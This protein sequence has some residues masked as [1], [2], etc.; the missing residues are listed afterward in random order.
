MQRSFTF[1]QFKGW[2]EVIKEDLDGPKP[3]LNQWIGK[4]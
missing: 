2:L 3:S 4:L 1:V